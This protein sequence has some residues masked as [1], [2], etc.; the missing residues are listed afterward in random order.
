[1]NF[2]FISDNNFKELLNR[3][4]LE[5]KKC[6]EHKCIKSTL[7]LSG[8]IIEAILT[9]YFLQFPPTGKTESQIMNSTLNDLLSWA[10][11]EN[12]ISSKEKDLAGV[13]KDYRNLIHPGREIRKG[14]KF[15][16]ETANISVSVLKIIVESVK[17]V[18]LQKYG[19]S[20]DEVFEKLKKDWHFKS[21]FDKVIIKLNQ[22]ERIKLLSQL[23]EFDKYEKSQWECFLEEG[24]IPNFP[25]YDLEDVKP[26]IQ[27]LKSLI[28]VAITKSYL[29]KMIKEI[30]TGNSL[31]A[32]SLFHLFHD[33]MDLLNSDEQE[34][35]TIYFINLFD[36]ISEESLTIIQEQTYSTIGKYIN[37]PKTIKEL[38]EFLEYCAVH[39]NTK[40]MNKEMDLIEQIFNSLSPTIKTQA[41]QSLTTFLTPIEKL[42]ED[43]KLFYEEALNRGFIK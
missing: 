29:I 9:E 34:L 36:K 11:S 16:E 39:F 38:N 19:H 21:V 14:E 42:P 4:Y 37:S 30:E 32:Y 1:M 20:A 2:D 6:I 7:V 40:Y 17:T 10:I 18:Y 25:L 15:S 28:P 41:E 26:L 3:D 33:N 22:N 23:V 24:P 5:L 13:V 43:I 8:S 31:D 12:V 27:Q 35:V